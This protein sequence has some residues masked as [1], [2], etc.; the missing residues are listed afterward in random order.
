M[1]IEIPDAVITVIKERERVYRTLSRK[2]IEKVEELDA[3]NDAWS[4]MSDLCASEV[5]RNIKESIDE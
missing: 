5:L 3:L 1:L 4:S 2:P